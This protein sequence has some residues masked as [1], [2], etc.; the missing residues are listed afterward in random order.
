MN[1]REQIIQLFEDG[2]L[3]FKTEK[4]I[5]AAMHIS[6]AERKAAKKVLDVLEN[7]GVIFADG[8]GRY[9]TPAQAGVITGT[10]AANARGFAFLIPEDKEEHDGD[11]FISRSSLHGALD[12]DRVLAL[13]VRGTEDEASVVKILSRG[14]KQVAGTFEKMGGA[15]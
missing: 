5:F 14:R 12:G 10:I 4:Q 3:A 13:K 15:C 2:K 7:D 8:H 6:P 9:S 11:Y 1:L